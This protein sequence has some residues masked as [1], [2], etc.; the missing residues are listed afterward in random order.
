[1]SRSLALCALL[2]PLLGCM[3]APCY[4]A[5]AMPEAHVIL[6]RP[7]PL[8]LIGC[9]VIVSLSAVHAYGSSG[10][11]DIDAGDISKADRLFRVP[12]P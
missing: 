2:L 11:I 4:P 9:R 6:L 8:C 1:M 10:A 12:P 3:T 5:Q 7:N